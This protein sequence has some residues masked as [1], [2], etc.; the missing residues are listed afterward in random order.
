ML[1]SAAGDKR[2]IALT[3]APG[4]SPRSPYRRERDLA[5]PWL[6]YGGVD[7]ELRHYPH[8][9]AV[10][11]VLAVHEPRIASQGRHVQ[12][13]QPIEVDIEARVGPVVPGLMPDQLG[14]EPR[15]R[16]KRER[17]DAGGAAHARPE[18][19]LT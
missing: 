1:S 4:T 7:P 9:R 10:D 5:L 3:A 2:R 17:L 14:P 13:A 18:G 11:R 19:A 15:R 6:E 12:L 8:P 16:G